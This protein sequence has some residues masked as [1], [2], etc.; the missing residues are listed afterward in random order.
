MLK[1]KDNKGSVCSKAGVAQMSDN[2]GEILT[3]SKDNYTFSQ[4]DWFWI[5]VL[6]IIFALGENILTCSKK[7]K[8]L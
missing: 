2:F 1:E 4:R 5:L 3:I 6:L 8:G 7:S